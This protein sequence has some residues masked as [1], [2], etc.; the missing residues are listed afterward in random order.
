[1]CEAEKRQLVPV[2]NA[3]PEQI[4]DVPNNAMHIE[5]YKQRCCSGP[6]IIL[7]LRAR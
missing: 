7:L 3:V 2:G 1:M 4:N 6:D 5:A